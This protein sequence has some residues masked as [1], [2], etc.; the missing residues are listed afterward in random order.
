MHIDKLYF[1]LPEVLERWR[2]SETDLVY[3]AENDKL[4]LS[5]R[6]FGEPVEFG[7]YEEGQDG[8]R[9]RVPWEQKPFSG[10]LDLYASD[11]FQ[12]FRCG[13]LH[14][15]EF[16]TP[17]ADYASLYGEAKPVFVM[18]GDLLLRREE[19]DRFELQSGFS[20]GGSAMEESTFIASAD[21][22]EVRCNGYRFRLGPIQ[23][24]VV[25]A[26]HEA[27]QR[28]EA[29]QSGKAILSSAGSKSLRMADVFKSQKDWRQ[30]IRSD[31]RGGYRLNID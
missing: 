22:Q 25:R 31:R 11:V 10:L 20:S 12:L 29:W 5:V 2:I 8:E 1:T 13:E 23:A 16:R 15:S 28:G 14:V 27:A 26:L 19:R 4:R 6:V 7:D 9:F 17:R 24:Q 30:L 21:Y 3:L 18:I